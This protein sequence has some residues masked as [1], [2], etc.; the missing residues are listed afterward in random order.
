MKINIIVEKNKEGEIGRSGFQIEGRNQ[1]HLKVYLPKIES[2]ST[3]E[4]LHIMHA[5]M[6]AMV[7]AKKNLKRLKYILFKLP[8]MPTVTEQWDIMQKFNNEVAEKI[9]C[10]IEYKRV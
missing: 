4:E 6:N 1:K 9:G 5:C 8:V 3:K 2:K 7:Y 10:R